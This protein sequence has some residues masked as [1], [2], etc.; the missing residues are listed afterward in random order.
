MT[1]SIPDFLA[2]E[3]LLDDTIEEAEH[4]SASEAVDMI[5][6]I[7]KLISHARKAVD[8]LT[9]GMLKTLEGSIIRE[10]QEFRRVPAG[11]W[12]FDHDD[13][14][15]RVAVIASQP[16]EEGR[17]PSPHRA[18]AEAARMMRQIYASDSTK[19]KTGK[20]NSFGIPDGEVRDFVGEGTYKVTKRP[21]TTPSTPRDED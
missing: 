3:D 4:V 14:A 9:G 12:V 1:I 8:A 21:A 19:A 16:D 11:Q 6:A 17:E 20:L 2:V 13:I 5:L 7:D 15:K 10:G 18:A